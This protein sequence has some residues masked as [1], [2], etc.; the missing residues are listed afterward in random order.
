[1]EV[2]CYDHKD[3]MKFKLV[4][5]IQMIKENNLHAFKDGWD[6]YI[7]LFFW[8][9][10]PP[11]KKKEKIENNLRQTLYGNVVWLQM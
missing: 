4:F 8:I 7:V 6:V 11:P 5:K 2:G 9:A 10:P 3:L 1:M